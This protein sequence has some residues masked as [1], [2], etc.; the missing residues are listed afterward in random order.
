MFNPRILEDVLI[1]LHAC[2]SLGKWRQTLSD[3]LVITRL[4]SYI[5]MLGKL[6]LFLEDQPDTIPR[7]GCVDHKDPKPGS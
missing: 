1:W 7:K 5:T 6:L 2:P 4:W 3:E